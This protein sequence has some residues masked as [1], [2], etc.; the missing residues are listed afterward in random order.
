MARVPESVSSENKFP[1]EANPW[2]HDDLWSM[3]LG[4]YT[5]AHFVAVEH[6]RFN[7]IVC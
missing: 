5:P 2:K 1:D 7:V 3:I 4:H 6:G